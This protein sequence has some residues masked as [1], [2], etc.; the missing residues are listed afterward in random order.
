MNKLSTELSNEELLNLLE[1]KDLSNKKEY[2][3]PYLNFISKYNIQSGTFEVPTKVLLELYQIDHPRVGQTG[4]TKNLKKYIDW[5]M[6]R[7]ILTFLINKNILEISSSVEKLLKKRKPGNKVVRDRKR[8]MEAFLETFNLK[9]GNTSI[10]VA[11]LV[12]LYDRWCYKYKR[13]KIHNNEFYSLLP[14]YLPYVNKKYYKVHDDLFKVVSLETI[15]RI[16]NRNAKK[17]I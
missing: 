14:I 4:F 17:E 15:K 8:H 3:N 1:T 2:E 10:E 6:N 11:V 5:K 9:P 13:K 7:N 16:T 12:D